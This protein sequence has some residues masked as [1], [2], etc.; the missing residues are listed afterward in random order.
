ML[1]TA[2]K[3]FRGSWVRGLCLGGLLVGLY[4]GCSG[5]APPAASPPRHSQEGERRRQSEPLNMV[6]VAAPQQVKLAEERLSLDGGRVSVA[7][8]AGWYLP[9]RDRRWLLRAQFDRRHAYPALLL[10]VQEDAEAEPLTPGTHAAEAAARLARRLAAEDEQQDPAAST[11]IQIGGFVGVEQVRAARAG[12]VRLERLLLVTTQP[13]RRYTLELRTLRGT[14][15]D[16]RPVA[17]ALAAALEF[18]QAAAD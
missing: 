18:R 9:P 4:G 3:A 17:Y 13:G 15:R 7:P 5:P 14:L 10:Y 11:L 8:P 6:R 1:A 16:F 2:G 12:S